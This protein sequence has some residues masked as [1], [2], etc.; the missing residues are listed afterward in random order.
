MFPTTSNKPHLSKSIMFPFSIKYSKRLIEN[1]SIDDTEVI[2]NYISDFIK[3]KSGSDI[4]LNGNQLI[5]S[6]RLFEI[7]WGINLNILTPIEKGKFNLISNGNKCILSYEFFMYR[8]FIIV[9]LFSIIAGLADSNIWTGLICFAFLG[10]L[11]WTIA[12]IRHQRMFAE[13]ISSI[14]NLIN[15][16][17]GSS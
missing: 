17:K 1:V 8:L 12:I 7:G 2:M 14:D 11:N 15:E 10:V 13:I 3:N 9:S 4:I 5:F 6:S 16:K